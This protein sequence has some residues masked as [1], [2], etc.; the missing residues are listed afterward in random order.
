MKEPR[1]AILGAGAGGLCMAI[2]LAQSG[3]RSFTVFEKATSVGGTWREN[4][5]PGAACDVPSMLYCFSFAPKVDWSRKFAPQPEIR[6]YFEGLVETFG[7]APHLRLGTEIT[8]LEWDEPRR[9]WRL[10][11]SDGATHEFEHVVSAIGQLHVPRIPALPGLDRFGGEVVHSARFGPEV[12]Y[13]GRDVVVVGNAA[14][15]VQIVPR[16]AETA[17][18]VTVLQRTPNW[19]GFRNDRKYT[20][21]EHWLFRTLPFVARAVRFAQWANLD[22]RFPILR[23]ESRLRPFFEWLTRREMRRRIR[24]AELAPRLIPSYS[25]GCNRFLISDDYLET[26]ARP[27]VALVTHP[28]ESFVPAG[29]KTEDGRTHAAELVVLATGFDTQDFLARLDVRGVGGRSLREAYAD[30]A[31]AYLGIT[32]PAFPNLYQLYGPNTNL[33]HNSILVMIEAAADHV[34]ALLDRAQRESAVR[35]EVT[36]QAMAAFDREIQAE[37]G[38]LVFSGDCQ[39]WYKRA[40]G[41]VTNNWAFDTRT[42]RRRTREIPHAAYRFGA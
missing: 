26:Y 29:V 21:F 14:S 37:L 32:V 38:R 36:E 7:L 24:S 20:A 16:V 22:L 25:I 17:R 13:A 12:S 27:N 34:I 3:R 23:S 35:I 33:G 9:I 6:A 11:S 1:V 31:Y 28:V 15:A 10:E 5:Y 42:Y 19:V 2:R 18:T 8:R 40:D 4:R 39:S 41:R 30:G